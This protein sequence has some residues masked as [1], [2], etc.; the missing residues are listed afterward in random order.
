MELKFYHGTLVGNI[1]NFHPF[2]HF[3]SRLAAAEAACRRLHLG[4]RGIPYLYEVTLS[5]SD[6]NA[7]EMRDW[8]SP[9]P[10]NLALALADHFSGTLGNRFKDI[11]D[12]IS[13]PEAR[14]RSLRESQFAKIQ[15]LLLPDVKGIFYQN[16]FEG[17]YNERTLCLI[18]I[19]CISNKRQLEFTSQELESMFAELAEKHPR[20]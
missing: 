9:Q 15:E 3:G 8:A 10:R 17:V 12:K 5:L 1:Q 13:I 2:S 7:I 19:E 11:A 14:N 16:E 6:E 4:E 18:D 20:R